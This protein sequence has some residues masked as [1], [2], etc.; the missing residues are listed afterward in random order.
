M[1]KYKNIVRY[2]NFCE[3]NK[4]VNCTLTSAM[5]TKNKDNYKLNCYTL[6]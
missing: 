6:C 1:D 2:L 5:I 4:N 3:K